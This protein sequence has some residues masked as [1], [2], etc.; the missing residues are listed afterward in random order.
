MKLYFPNPLDVVKRITLV[1]DP[2]LSVMPPLFRSL[3]GLPVGGFTM[4][5]FKFEEY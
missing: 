4:D 1:W 3:S 2:V 5:I